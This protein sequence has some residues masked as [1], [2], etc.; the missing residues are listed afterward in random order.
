MQRSAL[1]ILAAT[2]LC[3]LLLVA[4]ALA[5]GPQASDADAVMSLRVPRIIA[6]LTS[7]ALLALAGLCLQTVLRNPLADPYVLGTSGGAA[8]GALV[9]LLVGGALWYGAIIGAIS[10]VL[11]LAWLMR[12]VLRSTDDS[13]ADS[14]LLAGVMIA[15]F[16]GAMTQLLLALLPDEQF[17][18]A[19]FW[20]VGDLSGAVSV[21]VLSV[22]ALI[23]L[24]ACLTLHRAFA[25][26]P[27][28]E[29]EAFVLG[30]AVVRARAWLLIIAA[31]AAAVVVANVGALGFTGLVAPHLARRFLIHTNAAGARSLIALS[32][33]L[34]A[35]FVLLADTVARTIALLL[36]L[37][38]G[39]VM[40]CIGAPF[41][42]WILRR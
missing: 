23:A 17:R 30:L 20:L 18:G 35:A 42:V 12:R 7:G 13:A 37:P 41:F 16:T 27:H 24:T 36:E 19:V 38:A 5:L 39:A 29:R 2:A 15:A 4:A 25:L 10:A 33:L 8:S 34:G 40:A 14:L 1:T 6:A 22:A 28:G 11:L 31:L 9:A 3:L 32:A 26:L 21:P